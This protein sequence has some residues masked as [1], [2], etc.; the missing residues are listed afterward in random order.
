MMRDVEVW[1]EDSRKYI[2]TNR[3]VS[4]MTIFHC[5]GKWKSALPISLGQMLFCFR[6]LLQSRQGVTDG[7]CT[8]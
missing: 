5:S 1:D 3:N 6:L 4:M 2:L 8:E 7:L